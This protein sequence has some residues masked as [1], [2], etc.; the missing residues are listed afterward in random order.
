M[1]TTNQDGLVVI[2]TPESRERLASLAERTGQS[3]EACLQ[4][5]VDEFIENWE[6]HLREVEQ[7]DDGE[8]RAVLRVANE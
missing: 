2:L 3:V 4:I 5:A 1:A 7:I 6:T 8:L